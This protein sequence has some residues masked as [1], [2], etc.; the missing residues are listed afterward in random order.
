L[1]SEPQKRSFTALAVAIVVAALVVSASLFAFYSAEGTVTKTSNVTTIVTPTVTKTV[2]LGGVVSSALHYVVFQQVGACS[3]EFWGMPWSV[4]IGNA[5][6]V[7]PAGTPLP[8]YNYELLGTSDRNLTVIVFALPNG[9]YNFS[10]GP[11][12]GFFTP[13]SG[14]AV[15]SGN[16]VLVDI[17]YT[18]TSCVTT[19][20]QIASGTSTQASVREFR[21]TF[22]QSGACSPPVYVAPWSVT[23]GSEVEAEPAGVTLPIPD[24]YFSASPLYANDSAIVF[25]VPDGTYHF[26]ITPS[27]AFAQTSGT[28]TVEG[29][30]VTVLLTGPILACI[31]TTTTGSV[32]P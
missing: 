8:L 10:V 4:T 5:T 9:T 11:S 12:A 16:D 29:R 20:G 15:V 27:F 18:G 25:S 32:P 13:Q 30:D 1:T 3:P 24:G 6:E 17:A 23:L 31:T 2:T 26:S 14:K 22:V 7:Q 19:M 28:A 21:V